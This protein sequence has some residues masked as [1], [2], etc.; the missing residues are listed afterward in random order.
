MNALSRMLFR[1]ALALGLATIDIG[2]S[3][4]NGLVYSVDQ[5]SGSITFS[6]NH[7][8][9]F[10]QKAGSNVSP[11]AS[12][13]TST[14]PSRLLSVSTSMPHRLPCLGARRTR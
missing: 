13:S 1:G 2:A 10:R 8:G 6:V 14:N 12:T 7:F 5:R 11:A 9:L 3:G 4:A